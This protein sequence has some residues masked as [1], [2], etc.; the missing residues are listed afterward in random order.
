MGNSCFRLSFALVTSNLSL[1]NY[2]NPL[3]DDAIDF[4]PRRKLNVNHLCV[5]W[6]K[7]IAFG[8][9]M[10]HGRDKIWREEQILEIKYLK[11]TD[12]QIPL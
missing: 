4:P 7:A 11:I 8:E 2:G 6:F 3:S 1:E 9:A 10:K 5:F 12:H